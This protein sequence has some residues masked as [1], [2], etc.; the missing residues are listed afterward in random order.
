MTQQKEV[1]MMTLLIADTE[2]Y[3]DAFANELGVSSEAALIQI[4][5]EHRTWRRHQKTE[6]LPSKMEWI[7][8]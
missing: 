1:P 3:I 6:H 5:S 2:K 7:H 4:I 8:E